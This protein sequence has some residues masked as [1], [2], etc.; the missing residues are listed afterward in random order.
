MRVHD[1]FG[2]G[3]ADAATSPRTVDP[4]PSEVEG[5]RRGL[6]RPAPS[7]L[8]AASAVVVPTIVLIVHASLY[9]AWIVDDAA[10]TFS[11]ARNM[12]AGSGPVVQAGVDPVEG[13]SNPAWL[14][15]HIAGTWL[16]LFDRGT[17]FGVPDYV[18]FPKTLALVLFVVTLVGCYRAARVITSKPALVTLVAGVAM[19]AI[20]SFVIWVVSGLENSLLV[21]TAVGL[22]AVLAPAVVEGR[23]FTPRAAVWC[24]LLAALAALTRPDGLVYA[25]AYPLAALLAVERGGL[26]RAAGFVGLSTVAFAVPAGLYLVWRLTTFGAWLPNTAVAK[27]QGLPTVE[28]LAPLAEFAMNLGWPFLLTVPVVAIAG[29][30]WGSSARRGLLA[31]GVP[32]LLALV[33]FVVLEADWMGEYRFASPVWAVG[34]LLGAS[35]MARLYS[36]LAPRRWAVAV[37]AVAVVGG[38]ASV[39][40]EMQED[41]LEFT[42]E[43]TTSVCTVAEESGRMVNAYADLLGLREGS[44]FTADL[45][46][47]SLTSRLRV[48]DLAGLVDADIA[49][50]WADQDW[51]GFGDHVYERVRPTFIKGDDSYY[52]LEPGLGEDPRFARDYVE[53]AP[54]SEKTDYVRRDVVAD[55]AQLTALR[56]L[57][58]TRLVPAAQQA[59]STPLA[60]CGDRLVP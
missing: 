47:S 57:A 32:F 21:A 22:A 26:R 40:P 56:T 48:V 9:G 54:S 39:F 28:N 24:G 51:A 53:V 43:P 55:P 4:R 25:G 44:V 19:A 18:A 37:V 14:A 10:I 35:S 59:A 30:V 2:G 12:A 8:A 15:L 17:W 3:A 34:A 11:Y 41:A 52:F 23:L 42:V 20:P 58:E 49:R 5:R 33:A 36:V 16:G 13:Y 27:S 6:D 7:R 38:T 31:I 45:G 50:L 46:G 60:T 1:G 29:I